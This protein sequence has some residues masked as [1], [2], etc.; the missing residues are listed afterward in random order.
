MAWISQ[1]KVPVCTLF[2]RGACTREGCKYRHVKVSETAGICEAFVK[3]YCAKGAACQLKHELPSK[4]HKQIHPSTAVSEKKKDQSSS[5]TGTFA[6]A[7]SAPSASQAVRTTSV[8]SVGSSA[9][10]TTSVLPKPKDDDAGLS[11]R[12]NIRFT[13]KHGAGFPSLF[14]GLHSQR[15]AAK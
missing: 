15:P 3:G 11:I 10:A 6:S 14:E 4:K 9:S 12:P 8:A 2:L 1:N 13:S 5:S 7:A